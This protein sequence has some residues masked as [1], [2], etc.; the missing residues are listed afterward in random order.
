MGHFSH[1]FFGGFP[2]AGPPTP[3]NH[4]G[5]VFVVQ[6]LNRAPGKGSMGISPAKMGGLKPQK[7]ERGAQHLKYVQRKD[8]NPLN[9]PGTPSFCSTIFGMRDKYFWDGLKATTREKI[10][11]F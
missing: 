1:G 11:A 9:F 10:R 8:G 3:S 6:E 4:L 7:T 2:V 5:D